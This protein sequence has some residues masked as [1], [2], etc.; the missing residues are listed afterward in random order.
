MVELDMYVI[1]FRRNLIFFRLKRSQKASKS[2]REAQSIAL[3]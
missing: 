1:I 2:P 3:G